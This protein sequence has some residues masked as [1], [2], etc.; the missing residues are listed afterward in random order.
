VLLMFGDQIGDFSDKYKTSLAERD[1]NYS[2]S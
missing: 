1:T 2:N